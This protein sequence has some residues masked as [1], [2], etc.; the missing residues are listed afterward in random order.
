MTNTILNEQ[1]T[2]IYEFSNWLKSEYLGCTIDEQIVS[3]AS[4][5]FIDI[6]S[7]NL[8]KERRKDFVSRLM[9]CGFIHLLTDTGKTADSGR[10]PRGFVPIFVRAFSQVSESVL[11]NSIQNLCKY[12]LDK[13]E[14]NKVSEAE[15][16]KYLVK[17]DAMREDFL[18]V[19]LSVIKGCCASSEKM[20]SSYMSIVDCTPHGVE[21]LYQREDVFLIFTSWLEFTSRVLK[22][23]PYN[24]QEFGEPQ[25]MC[26]SALNDIDYD[27]RDTYLFVSSFYLEDVDNLM[28]DI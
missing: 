23:I 17:N 2:A 22:N 8:A 13:A 25:I 20:Q 7:R 24:N 9:V 21:G 27:I 1:T 5:R 28:M 16:W 14:D 4:K 12:L 3:V 19:L 11:D 26:E 6:K 15:T 10:I 18:Y